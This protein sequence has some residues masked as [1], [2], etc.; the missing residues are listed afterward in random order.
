MVQALMAFRRGGPTG[1]VNPVAIVG[2]GISGL[3]AAVDLSSRGIP[4]AV[5][6]Q[7]PF[8]GGRAYSFKDA[9]TGDTVDNGQHVLI[10]ACKHTLHFLERIGTRHL[11]Q[12]Q[13]NPSLLF[14]HPRRG[15]RTLRIMP[16]PPPLH[17]AGG[18]LACGLFS[19]AD[20]LRILRGGM[21]AGRA[22][23]RALRDA[24]IAQWL[25]A[26]G[27]S[28]EA[29]RSFWEPLAVSVM[30]EHCDKASAAV[31]VEALRQAFLEGRRNS[32]M[33]IPSVGLSDLYVDASAS[34]ISEHGGTVRCSAEVEGVESDQRSVHG[35]RLRDGSAMQCS[36]AILALPPAR[37]FPVLPEHLRASGFLSGVASLPFSPIVSIHLWF[38]RDV[39]PQDFVGV[40]G[41]RIQW[42][43]RRAGH[44]SLVMS[45]AHEYVSATNEDLIAAG[46]EDLRAV[47][48]T[49]P[50]RPVHALVIREKRATF[51][52][53]P[54]TERFRPGTRTPL[55]NLFLAGDW[56]ATGLPATIEG[57]VI[58]GE[59]AADQAWC[60]L[61]P[62][63]G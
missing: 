15:F 61:S 32:A 25:E 50:E 59:R 34:F 27:Q 4:V 39:M 60:R 56:T 21:A 51:S 31:F 62:L 30:N 13:K 52:C 44:V 22:S 54:E 24:T 43:F 26:S 46:M 55:E 33:M 23:E 49:V 35:V 63:P 7:K 3:A 38:D 47:V 29:R 45:A 17:L 5:L 1:G 10:A 42:M 48:P 16:F 11:L 2:G 19:V 37:L 58:S 12:S 57:A 40:I 8:L 20:R 36:A 28:E 18:V 14:H 53:T 41:R 9:V 6:E